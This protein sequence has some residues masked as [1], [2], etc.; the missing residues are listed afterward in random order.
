MLPTGLA[1]TL[2]V[3]AVP[4][5]NYFVRVRAQGVAGTSP[6][7]PDIV[8]SVGAACQLPAVPTGLS[9]GVAGGSV[10]LQWSGTGPFRL[11]A[12][13]AP[14][15]SNVFAGEVGPATS[16][17][18]VVVPGAYFVR[19]HARNSCGLSLPS[20]EIL[21]EVQ[22]P[23]AP[24]GF[25]SSVIGSQLTLRW[26][27]PSTAPT[28]GGY[29]LEAGSGPGLA[30][31]AT[32]PL[33]SSPPSLVVQGVPAGTYYARIRSTAGAA[34]APSPDLAFTIGPPPAATA[35]VTFAG[36]PAAGT[37]FTTLTEQEF[38][39]E[40]VSGPWESATSAIIFRRTSAGPDLNGEIRV[41]R[42][43]GLPF[44]MSSVRLYSSV[45]PIP[46]V[47]R[48]ERSGT[49]VFTSAGT[50]PNTFGNYATVANPFSHQLV[51]AVYITVTNPAVGLSGNP[52]GV[53]D[54]VLWPR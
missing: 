41:T 46:Y 43:G 52:V 47:L 34:G 45:T 24:T 48:G 38:L 27:P 2:S 29:A 9:A 42:T 40:N 30:D 36:L 32:L 17:A 5:G 15:T 39:V 35:T 18:A 28:P 44:L 13:R 20:N 33:P 25:A 23:S 31:V 14:G 11:V 3:P 49:P 54:I 8:V 26:T 6:P 37:L 16:L 19:V 10:T 7:S 50:V 21:A 51:D 4:A 1:T 22:V 53:D 12:G